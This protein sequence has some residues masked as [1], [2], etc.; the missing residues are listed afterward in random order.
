MDAV[1]TWIA[2]VGGFL[3]AASG[4]V[5]YFD[6]RSRRDRNAPRSLRPRLIACELPEQVVLG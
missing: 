4:V 6:Y 1:H 2:V 5:K 3:T